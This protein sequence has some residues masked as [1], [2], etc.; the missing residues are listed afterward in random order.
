M[1]RI[2]LFLSSFIIVIGAASAIFLGCF[3]TE[4]QRNHLRAE[5]GNTQASFWVGY[6]YQN[7]EGASKNEA[8]AR[9]WYAKAAAHGSDIAAVNLGLMSLQGQG[10]AKDEK[11][12]LV[13][14][15]KAGEK[16]N[17][18]AQM[19]AARCAFLGV[20]MTRDESEGARWVKRAADGGAPQAV[21][22][23][24][25][26]YLG[27]IG[28]VQDH[29]VAI[30]WL[31]ISNSKQAK[32]LADSLDAKNSILDKLPPEERALRWK[33]FYT[34]TEAEVRAAFLHILE[35][36]MIPEKMK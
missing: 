33:E 5:F 18:K 12:A 11:E 26:L 13:L 20:G 3:A 27:G 34:Q 24:G 36:E 10:G 23:M 8:A 25:V 15:I 1:K 7:G 21:A 6:A 28:V 9:R 16:G 30:K 14:F 35:D 31:K 29:D 4:F 32:I 22:L 17:A 2:L 19:N